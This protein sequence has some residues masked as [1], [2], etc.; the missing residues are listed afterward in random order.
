MTAVKRIF[1]YLK[2]TVD[3]TLDYQPET[4]PLHGYSDADFARDRDDRKSTT[5]YTFKVSSAAISWYSGKQNTVSVS[6]ANAE[7]L[8]LGAAAREGL[9]LQQLFEEMGLKFRSTDIFENSQAVLALA[10]NPVH[11]SKQKHIEV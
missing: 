9:F 6:T 11:C 3:M 10:R 5:G 4:E 1:G 7:H 8:A 2:D